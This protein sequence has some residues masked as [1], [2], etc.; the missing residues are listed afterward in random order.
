MC[1]WGFSPSDPLYSLTIS[2]DDGPPL[3]EPG[4]TGVTAWHETD[5]RL[6]AFGGSDEAG[7]WMAFPS[8]GVFRFGAGNGAVIVHPEPTADVALVEDTFRRSVVPMALQARGDQV[9]HASAVVGPNGVVALCAVSETGKSTMAYGLGRRGFPL[10]ADDAVAFT[11]EPD[12]V[13]AAP[14][15][16][17]LRLRPSSAAHFGVGQGAQEIRVPEPAPLDA[18]CVLEATNR[19]TLPIIEPLAGADA[20]P[21]VLAH[22]YCFNLDDVDRNRATVQA[23]LELTN[24]ARIF[25]VRVAR[26]LER[27]SGIL[28]AVE[29]EVL[30][31]KATC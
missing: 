2:S 8:V 12:K 20:F 27:L 18:V 22:A 28:D 13:R 7:H 19:G 1:C 21:A 26:G 6:A 15:P 31:K 25:R 24:R 4:S 9:L 11:V 17:A 23:Y 14:L 10:W 30:A 3:P 16:F 5:G 29:A